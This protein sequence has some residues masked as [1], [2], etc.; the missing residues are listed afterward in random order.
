MTGYYNLDTTNYCHNKQS[1][2]CIALY[3]KLTAITEKEIYILP[4]PKKETNMLLIGIKQYMSFYNEQAT[5]TTKKTQ[6][7]TRAK[8]K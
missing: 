3:H 2:L 5:R 1:N 7:I 6:A 4:K 8:A